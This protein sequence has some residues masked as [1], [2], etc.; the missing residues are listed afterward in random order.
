M[1]PAHV[2]PISEPR[3]ENAVKLIARPVSS[4]R[5]PKSHMNFWDH[6]GHD[7][8]TTLKGEGVSRVGSTNYVIFL[9]SS[10]V[11][12]AMYFFLRKQGEPVLEPLEFMR[13]AQES[14]SELTLLTPGFEPTTFQWQD[15]VAGS[16]CWRNLR[17]R[18][19]AVLNCGR[20]T[21]VPDEGLS[22]LNHAC[23]SP[24]RMVHFSPHRL[25]WNLRRT[26]IKLLGFID[27]L[28]W[29]TLLL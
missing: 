20:S 13:L 11:S 4:C 29:I 1:I 19:V 8:A 16:Q 6:E 18:R 24:M 14:N 15:R 22:I 9:L 10:S 12:K 26:F 23:T 7:E 28:W 17:A 21:L 3:R 2:L 25:I 27:L 5:P